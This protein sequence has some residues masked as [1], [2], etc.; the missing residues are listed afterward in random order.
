MPDGRVR[1]RCS[2]ASENQKLDNY[3]DF[4][5]IFLNCDRSQ[6]GAYIEYPVVAAGTRELDDI[7]KQKDLIEKARELGKNLAE[8]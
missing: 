3:L 7:L 2:A 1:E 4:F 5:L 8:G 6:L